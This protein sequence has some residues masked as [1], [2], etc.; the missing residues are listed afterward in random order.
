MGQCH[1]LWIDTGTLW[2]DQKRWASESNKN[3]EEVQSSWPYR[4]RI[5]ND[6][7]GRRLWDGIVDVYVQFDGGSRDGS[8]RNPTATN[9]TRQNPTPTKP[10]CDKPHCD[11]PHIWQTSTAI[12]PTAGGNDAERFSQVS[13][14]RIFCFCFCNF[15]SQTPLRL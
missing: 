13:S 12:K 15:S 3:D 6:N 5:G 9:P 4:N 14:F 7:G 10:T 11:K 8:E 2:N 1:N